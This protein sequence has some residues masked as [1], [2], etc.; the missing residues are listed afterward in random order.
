[1]RLHRWSRTAP[2]LVDAALPLVC[3]PLRG[4][5]APLTRALPAYISAC[6]ARSARIQLRLC[7]WRECSGVLRG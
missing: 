6:L 5:G 4:Q 2:Q 3:R 7:M 1:M